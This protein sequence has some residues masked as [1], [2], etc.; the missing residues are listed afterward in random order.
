VLNFI[1][2][3]DGAVFQKDLG[4]DTEASVVTIDA[5]ERNVAT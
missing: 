1:V 4:A 5:Y 2:N 3:H